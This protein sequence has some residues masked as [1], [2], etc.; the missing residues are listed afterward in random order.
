MTLHEVY[1]LNEDETQMH[2]RVTLRDPIMLS[3]PYIKTGIW[4]D[5]GESTDE[6]DCVVVTSD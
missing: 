5:I 3:A 6:Y 1:T 2:Y 4:I